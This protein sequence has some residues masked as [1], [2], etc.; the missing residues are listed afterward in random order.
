ATQELIQQQEK[1]R[2]IQAETERTVRQMEAMIRVMQFYKLDKEGEQKLL[3]EA[4]T[5]LSG[6]SQNQMRQVIEQ[7]E[8]AAKAPEG[9]TQAKAKAEAY[10]KHREIV[11]QLKELLAKRD[12]L[13]TLEQAAER[14]DKAAKAQRDIHIITN[15]VVRV[16][17]DPKLES[18]AT[19]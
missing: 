8:A 12:A 15:Q 19:T 13:T 3:Q 7:L 6:L 9:E 14:L 4:A 17:S 10:A 2:L 11:T 5:T 18:S 16:Q 1:Q